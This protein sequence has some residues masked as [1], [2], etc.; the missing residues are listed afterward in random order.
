[1]LRAIVTKRPTRNR[2]TAAPKLPQPRGLLAL[3]FNVSGEEYVVFEM[4]TSTVDL[5]DEL[6]KAEKAVA[7]AAIAGKSNAQIASERETSLRTVANQLRSVYAKLGVSSRLALA[8]AC[9]CT[10]RV[11]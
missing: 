6:S 7:R 3:R 11:G 8:R 1:M 10:P 4:P 5:P 2:R 9:R